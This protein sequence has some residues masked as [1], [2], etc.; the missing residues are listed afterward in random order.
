MDCEKALELMSAELDGMCTEQ[1]RAALQAHLEACAD[2]RET[3]QQLRA[4]DEA[5]QDA[6]LEPPQ[7]LHDNVMRQIR[8]EKKPARRVWLPAAAI[9]AAAALVLLAGQ[10]GIL[11]LPGFD[12]ENSVTVNVGS[13][14]ERI[15]ERIEPEAGEPDPAAA[16]EA[17]ALSAETQLDVLLLWGQGTPA[18]LRATPYET[19]KTGARLYRVTGTL[20][21]ELLD[22]YAAALYAADSDFSDLPEQEE[23]CVLVME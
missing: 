3:Y 14:A 13:A 11:S 6:E 19:T 10:A 1:E 23:A 20:A 15:F 4:L 22:H 16:E 2:C 18:E 21:Q 9:A 17:A 5:L 7:A 12:R 8:K